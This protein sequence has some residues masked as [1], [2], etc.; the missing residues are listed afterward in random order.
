M[1]RG[2][3]C[4]GDPKKNFHWAEGEGGYWGRGQQAGM[5]RGK[6]LNGIVLSSGP[7]ISGLGPGTEWRLLMLEE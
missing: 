1:Y 6:W 4:R 7:L 5:V 3:V 2:H